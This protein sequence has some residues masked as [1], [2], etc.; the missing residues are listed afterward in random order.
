MAV[1]WGGAFGADLC[2]EEEGVTYS[3]EQRPL[4]KIEGYQKALTSIQPVLARP[5]AAAALTLEGPT[6]KMSR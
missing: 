4:F 5:E 3:G 6:F 2:V 1:G